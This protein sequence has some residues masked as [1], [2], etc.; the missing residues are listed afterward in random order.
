MSKIITAA[1][2]PIDEELKSVEHSFHELFVTDCTRHS[3]KTAFIDGTTGRTVSYAQVL[4]TSKRLA[5][6]FYHQ[7]NVRAGDVVAL[8][9]PNVPE[10]AAVFHGI[11]A[12]GAVVSPLNSMFTAAEIEKQARLS[13]AKCVIT[14]SHFLAQVDEAVKAYNASAERQLQVLVLDK[15]TAL[16]PSVT[17]EPV[18]ADYVHTPKADDVIVLPFSSGT[19]GLPKGVQL[20]NRN[21]VANLLQTKGA[22]VLDDKAIVMAVL[23]YFHIYG[24]IVILHGFLHAGGIQIT[25]PKFDMELYLDLVDKHK[26][27]YLFVAP[28][29]MVGFVKHPKTKTIDM[30]HVKFVMSGAA[31]LGEEVQRMT[32]PFFPN[33]TIGQGYGLT[34]TSPVIS[35]C[36]TGEKIYG[37]AGTLIGSTEIR[38]VKVPEKE[39]DEAVDLGPGEGEGELWVRGPQV[40]KGYLRAEDTAIVF[41]EPGWFRTGDLVKVDEK[42]NIFIT[43][44]I[45]ELIKYKGYQVAPAELEAVIQTH[46]AVQECIVVGVEDKEEG[47]GNEIPRAWVALKPSV[48]AEDREKTAA[49]I[50]AFVDGKVAPYKKLRGGVKIVDAIPKTASGKLLRRVV[51]D[52]ENAERKA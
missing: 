50:V 48:A 26:A 38:V 25:M 40:M 47:A 6:A 23:P 7:L 34:E 42:G 19:T 43:D 21:L 33:A 30:S 44:R 18:P 1:R 35:V 13:N 36:P 5:G 2:A 15:S 52:Q 17:I 24:M 14:V 28:P 37:S 29:I 11:L 51:K 46:P 12:L 27:N 3:S 9:M 8:M 49:E 45:K 10:Y 16:D 31:P 20:T 32:E 4:G 39:T 22:I 41:P